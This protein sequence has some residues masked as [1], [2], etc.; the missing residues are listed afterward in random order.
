[1]IHA[2]SVQN[3]KSLKTDKV[4]LSP[5]TILAGVNNAGKTTFIQSILEFVRYHENKKGIVLNVSPILS[6]YKTKVLDHDTKNTIDF[7]MKLDTGKDKSIEIDL[8]FTY[9]EK[10]KGGFL[11]SCKIINTDKELSLLL[12]KDDPNDP[13]K[14]VSK[15]G[16]AVSY[17]RLK[18]GATPP[19]L[20]EGYGVFEFIGFVPFNGKIKFSDNEKLSDSFIQER[21]DDYVSVRVNDA[22]PLLD[23]ISNVKYIGPLRNYPKE[24]YFFENRGLDI[25]SRGENT[26]EVLERQQKT[27]VEYF[28]DIKDTKV[29][30]TTLLEAVQY[31]IDYFHPGSTLSIEH[32]AENMIQILIN[33]HT[34]NNSGFGFSQLL[35]IIVQALTMDKNQLLLLEQPEIHLHP[36]LEYKLAYFMLCIAKNKRQIIAETHS[37]HIVNQ[38]IMSKMEDESIEKLFRMYF[39]KKTPKNITNFEKINITEYGEIQEW[40]EGFFDKYLKFTRELVE[41]RKEK[42][43]AKVKKTSSEL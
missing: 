5:L 3:F 40:P 31:W 22:I 7:H 17:G 13:Y 32:V 26:F 18:E 10:A 33:G 15:E 21:E 24:F 6:N 27:Q 37:E 4:E 34:I 19:P 9:N 2:F 41:K 25:D 11:S 20:F 12:T 23:S 8:T 39:L 30:E 38:L 35:P 29:T 42:A 1:M 28:K 16:L 14:I 36:E 43:L